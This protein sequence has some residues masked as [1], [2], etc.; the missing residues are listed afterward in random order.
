M[1]EVKNVGDGPFVGR[2]R[3]Q[4][5]EIPPNASMIVET[6]AVHCWLGNPA[7]KDTATW[8]QREEEFQRIRFMW[9]GERLDSPGAWEELRPA[10][11]VYDLST[12]DRYY[13][14]A[15]DPD[16]TQHASTHLEGDVEKAQLIAAVRELQQRL[17]AMGAQT[18]NLDQ[19][20]KKLVTDNP[21]SIKVGA[22]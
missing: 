13:T 14:V 17:D 12:H 20:Q 10:L 16:G 19:P 18:P 4:W 5:V 1:Y 15:D 21:R 2:Y 8:K 9:T 11:E 22:E 3:Q 7:V 6:G